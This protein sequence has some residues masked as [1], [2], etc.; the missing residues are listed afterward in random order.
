M[1]SMT[2]FG[3]SAGAIPNLDIEI[4][5]KSINGRFLDVRFHL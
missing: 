5:V 2:G 3:T 1:K 4:S